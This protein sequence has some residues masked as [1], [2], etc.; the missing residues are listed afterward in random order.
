MQTATVFLLTLV[1]DRFQCLALQFFLGDPEIPF[2]L[3]LRTAMPPVLSNEL[4]FPLKKFM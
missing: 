4:E 3:T 2:H 1:V